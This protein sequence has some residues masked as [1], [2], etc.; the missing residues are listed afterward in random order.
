MLGTNTNNFTFTALQPVGLAGTP[1]VGLTMQLIIS[2]LIKGAADDDT[3]DITIVYGS[4][5]E[6]YRRLLITDLLATINARSALAVV[7]KKGTPPAAYTGLAGTTQFTYSTVP[8]VG[9]TIVNPLAYTP[10]FAANASLDKVSIFN[11]M[12]L[13]GMT[14]SAV[15]AEALAYC[16]TKRAFYIMDPPINGVADSLAVGLPGA[17]AGAATIESIWDGGTLPVSPNGAIYFPYLQTTDLVTGAATNAPPGGYVA[18]IFAR[19]DSNRGVWKS[20]AGL[21]TTIKGTTG[22]VP[23]GN[24][25]DPQQGVLNELGVNVLRT[26]PGIGTVVFGARTLVSENT[27][28]QQWK[29]VAVRRMALFLEQS[30]YA[31]LG[32]AVFEPNDDAALEATHAGGAGVHARALPPGRLPGSHRGRG[33]P[34]PVRQHD[35]VAGGHRQRDRQHPRRLRAAQAGGVR[36]HP[37][38]ADRRT[39]PELEEKRAWASHSQRN[40]DRFDPYKTYRFLVYFGKSTTPVAAVSKVSA[41]KRSSDVIEY[42]EGGDAITL[43]GL[44]RTKYEPITM[45]RGVTFDTDF[46][47]WANAAQVL[48]QG[49]AA[50]SLA[51]L[52]KEISI[53][54]LNEEAQPVH[55]YIVHRCWVSEFQALPDLDAGANAIAIEHIKLENEGW[56]RD[57]TLTE[58]KEA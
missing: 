22:V 57:L 51:A 45:E 38:R 58:A 13:P 56:E 1:P 43:K 41:L 9:W 52:R 11:L 36:R 12:V 25:T 32:W 17:P 44:G 20:P 7:S 37:D 24:M 30:L 48:E 33:V 8:T 42:K 53:V 40:I 16:E 10:V 14:N 35:D 23:W 6:T 4:T 2:N 46:E 19:E 29:Y 26:F 5:V 15:L 49:S 50:T 3:A 21:E 55:R 39:N 31:S 54:L 27:A 47:D 34:R 28:Y 18:G